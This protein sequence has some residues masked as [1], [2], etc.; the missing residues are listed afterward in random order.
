MVSWRR[1]QRSLRAE[2]NPGQIAAMIETSF[3]RRT[4]LVGL[5]ASS[6][7]PNPGRAQTPAALFQVVW[8]AK[9][10]P[11]E[12]TAME[13][14]VA[15]LQASAPGWWSTITQALASPGF[16]PATA[17]TLDIN[18]ITPKT[19]P[20]AT[21]KTRIIVDAPYV[22]SQVNNPDRLG[23]VAHEMVHVAQAYPDHAPWWLTEGIADYMRYY[24]LLPDD[25]GRGFDAA[26]TDLWG[27]YQAMGALLD[28]I[29]QRHPGAVR[30]AN[31]DLRAG[32]DGV[33]MLEKA[34]GGELTQLWR[35]Y[36]ATNPPAISASAQQAR[37]R[38]L[39]PH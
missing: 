29:E 20:A 1:P 6:A 17:I 21:V 28:F 10:A 13:A 2:A 36:L 31:A 8:S 30:S 5:G 3:D 33:A 7:A 32:G 37:E 15:R 11:G 35:A 27:G 16:T 25:P 9:L 24:V 19:I 26:R 22:L 18:T 23:M 39:A 38:A 14:W 34:G 4:L 12:R